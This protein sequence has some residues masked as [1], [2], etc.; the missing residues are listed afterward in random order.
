MAS[1]GFALAVFAFQLYHVYFTIGIMSGK[2][3]SL[4]YYDDPAFYTVA[5]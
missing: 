4:S 2:S 1:A 5:L 3:I